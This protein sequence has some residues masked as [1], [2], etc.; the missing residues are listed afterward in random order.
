MYGAQRR[1]DD[2]ISLVVAER[3][4]PSDPGATSRRTT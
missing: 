2:F 4:D 3:T 1:G